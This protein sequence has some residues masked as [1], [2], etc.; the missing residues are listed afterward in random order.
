M[1]QED[2]TGSPAQGG[3]L[4]P[5]PMRQ[6]DSAQFKEPLKANVG[7]DPQDSSESPKQ[8]E[9][10]PSERLFPTKLTGRAVDQV[11]TREQSWPGEG[12]QD[13]MRKETLTTPRPSMFRSSTHRSK[14][15]KA[16]GRAANPAVPQNP[17]EDPSCPPPPGKGT[18][19]KPST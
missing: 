7:S 16:W 17:R 10:S 19:N 4:A 14:S 6:R 13:P 15:L 18:K 8:K 9:F 1:G 12:T 3:V 11:E 5:I 2:R